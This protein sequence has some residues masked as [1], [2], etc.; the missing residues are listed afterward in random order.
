MSATLGVVERAHAALASACLGDMVGSPFEGLPRAQV[1]KLL[2]EGCS[3][4]PVGEPTDDTVLTKWVAEAIVEGG[5]EGARDRFVE[6]LLRGEEELRLRRGGPTTLSSIDRLRRNPKSRATSGATNGAAIRALPIGLAIPL[7]AEDELLKLVVELSTVTHGEAVAVAAASAIAHAASKAVEPGSSI[8][9]VVEKGVEGA[10]KFSIKLA[11][12]IE[13]AVKLAEDVEL[14]YLAEELPRHV[15]VGSL[16]VESVPTAFCIFKASRGDLRR[17]VEVAVKAGGDTDSVASMAG[18]LCGALRGP[19]NI[20]EGWLARVERLNLR[21]LAKGLVE[22]RWR[23]KQGV[24][25]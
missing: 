1:L 19:S 10:G 5:L 13:R 16:S 12:L 23:F 2:R 18:G 3:V 20:P 17:A 9:E 11:C 22:V 8:D 6:K 4:E 21:E 24:K 7:D 25:L 15:G 14:N